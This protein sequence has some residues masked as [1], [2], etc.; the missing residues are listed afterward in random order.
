MANAPL[1]YLWIPIPPLE[2]LDTPKHRVF[3]I[4]LFIQRVSHFHTNDSLFVTLLSLRGRLHRTNYP[5]RPPILHGILGP[6]YH[7]LLHYNAGHR[8]HYRKPH[9]R[10][11]APLGSLHWSLILIHHSSR[12]HQT[13]RIILAHHGRAGMGQRT[14]KQGMGY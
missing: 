8:A 5:I 7:P 9:Q 10:S 1:D 6:M 3:Q 4:R 13:S 12:I 14:S 2:I 11:V